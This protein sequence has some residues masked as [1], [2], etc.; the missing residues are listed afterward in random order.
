MADP[1]S[2][3]KPPSAEEAWWYDLSVVYPDAF[4]AYLVAHF[5]GP[6]LAVVYLFDSGHVALAAVL[7]ALW[8]VSASTLARDFLRKAV[9]R[10][11]WVFLWVW[12]AIAAGWGAYAL[13]VV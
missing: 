2:Q 3:R 12:L 10:L 13:L 7:G 8:L 5:L 6:P 4:T 9:S 1:D 11:S